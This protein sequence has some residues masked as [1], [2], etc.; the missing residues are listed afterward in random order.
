MVTSSISGSTSNPGPVQTPA[1][2]TVQRI[3]LQRRLTVGIVAALTVITLFFVLTTALFRD[4]ERFIDRTLT[5]DISIARL[6]E[7][8]GDL[9]NQIDDQLATNLADH[10]RQEPLVSEE[11]LGRFQG[12]LLQ[13]DTLVTRP[14]HR[15]ALIELTR[16]EASYTRQLREL[17]HHSR[18]RGEI[19]RRD[20]QRRL[21]AGQSISS[22]TNELSRKIRRMNDE[23]PRALNDPE[24]RQLLGSATPLLTTISRI[25]KDLQIVEAEIRL[26]MAQKTEPGR[27]VPGRLALP[28]RIQN[29]LQAVLGL[30]VK[31]I[32][33]SKS[34]LHTRVFGNIRSN[35]IEFKT[36]FQD[37]R[38]LLERPDS[39]KIEID[40]LLSGARER[41]ITVFAAGQAIIAR[42]AE[43]FWNRIH[44]TSSG[45][46]IEARRDFYA[47]LVFLLLALVGGVYIAVTFPGRIAGP[48]Q[49]LKKQMKGYRL[50][51]Q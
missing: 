45:L 8:F 37:L 18:R 31:S 33:G 35:I 30:I 38:D 12:T 28:D 6:Y 19:A 41:M 51:D 46:V 32:E 42:Q 48:L 25:E 14:E 5:P 47:T 49:Q 43:S 1:G 2:E 20:G 15:A 23:L 4:I 24:F 29:R 34:P 21:S 3:T 13:L 44:E 9:W 17:E 39:E 10:A 7:R 11:L 16:L 27:S 36:S 26:Y 50:G 40:D 22:R